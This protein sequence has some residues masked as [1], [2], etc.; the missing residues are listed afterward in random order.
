MFIDLLAC[1]V[2]QMI[3]GREWHGP[4]MFLDFFLLSFFIAA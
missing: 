2:S 1:I 3:S 4:F